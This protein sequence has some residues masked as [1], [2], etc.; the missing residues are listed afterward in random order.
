MNI[1][2]VWQAITANPALLGI[3]IFAEVSVV[4]ASFIGKWHLEKGKRNQ[5]N[6]EHKVD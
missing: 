1:I 4:C 5:N 3:V 6:A 2:E